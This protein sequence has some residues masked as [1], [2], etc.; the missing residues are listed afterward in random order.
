[1]GP[2]VPIHFTRFSPNYKLTGLPPT[3]VETLEKAHDIA[4]A[5]GLRYVYVGNVPGHPYDATFCPTCGASLISRQGFTV[6]RNVLSHGTC[7]A[8]G[9]RIPGIWR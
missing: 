3:P 1:V 7:P 9:A 5:A 4:R 8:C 2:D 6:T